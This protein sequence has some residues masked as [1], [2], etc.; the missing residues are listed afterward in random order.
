VTGGREWHGGQEH[1]ED[2]RG[3]RDPAHGSR[4]LEQ[5]EDLLA[6]S[7]GGIQRTTARIERFH[8]TIGPS[9]W[10]V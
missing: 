5:A 6:L 2:T 3:R 1:R 7:A 9:G 8:E 10:R 4:Q